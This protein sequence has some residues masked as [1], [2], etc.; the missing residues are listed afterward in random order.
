MEIDPEFQKT[1]VSAIKQLLKEGKVTFETIHL[2]KNGKKIPVEVSAS[3]FD[4][5]GK[6]TVLSI[7]RDITER[8]QVDKALKASEENFRRSL[9]ESPLGVRIVTDAGETIYANR[10]ILDIYGYDS[11]EQLKAIPVKKRYTPESFIEFQIRKEKRQLAEETPSEY[12][13]DIIRKDG[14]VRH[15]QVYRKE[16]IWNGKKQNQVIYQ[17][18]ALRK[19]LEET[20]QKFDKLFHSNPAAMAVTSMPERRFTDVNNAFVKVVGYSRKE[21]IGKTSK[22]LDIFI[23]PEKQQEIADKLQARGTIT[24]L[25]LKI[26]TKDGKI[27]DGLFSGE[28]IESHGKKYFLSVMIDQTERK[29][30]Q[31]KFRLIT[32]NMVDC[33]ALVDASG[34]YQYAT[35]SYRE[36]L[37]YDPE[38]MVGFNGFNLIHPDDQER[39]F[40]LYMECFEKGLRETSY[41]TTLLHKDGHYVPIEIKARAL[42]DPTGKIVGGVLNARDISKRLQLEQERLEVE[43]QKKVALNTLILTEERYRT[44]VENASDIIFRT[45]NNGHFT[46]VNPAALSITGYKKE[47]VIGMDYPALIRQDMRD[48][49]IKFFGRQFV[50][51]IKNTYS[52]FPVIAKDGRELWFGQ[53]TQ[54]IVEGG[55]VTG[56]QSVARDITER[57]RIEQALNDAEE[58]YRNIFLNSQTGLFRTDI[59]TGLMLEANDSM[60]HFA[61][62]KNRAE[63][64]SDNFNI[65]ERYVDPEARQKMLA[66]IKEHGQVAN[67]ETQFRRN[68]GSIIWIRLSANIVPAKGCLE[69][70]AEDITKEKDAREAL[71]KSEERYRSLVENANEAIIVIQDGK[72]K[73]VNSRAI[74]SFGY[75]GE[76]LLAS[77]I[78]DLIHPEDRDVVMQRYLQ[79]I[80]GDTTSSRH[81]YRTIH[82]SGQTPWI[83]ISSVLIDWERRPATLNLI[84]DMS[85]RMQAEED[86]RLLEERLQQAD[87][88]EAIGTLAGGIAHDFNN[89]LMGMQGYA[90]M[91]LMNLNQNDPNYERLKRIEEQ[92]RSGADLT[93]QLLGFARGGRYEVKATS[94]NEIIEKSSTMFGRTKKEITIHH[95]SCSDLWS[96]E[97]DRGQMEQVFLNLFVNAWQAMPGGGDIYLETQNALL[98]GEQA[99][100]YSVMPGK[101]VKITISDTGT[102]MDEKTRE[103]IF[104]PFFTTKEM[105]RGTGLGMATVYGIIKGHE[106]IIN[107][108][109]K[110]GKGTTFTIYLPASEKEVHKEE[111]PTDKIVMGTETILLIDDEKTVMEVNKELLESIGYTLYGAVSGQQG[112]DI[113]MEKK[114]SIDLII[115]DMIMPGIS[116]SDTFDRLREINPNVKILLSSGYSLTGKAQAIM[117]RGCN[118]FLQKPFNLEELSSKVREMLG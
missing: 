12:E 4:M 44:L 6:K 68:D 33:V 99:L 117:D 54:L 97:V 9:D 76:E 69:G 78:F 103:R 67:Y 5:Q 21:V 35:P 73:F 116:G 100:F 64:L 31:E 59:K 51:G 7:V 25:E 56:F 114:D 38:E 74:A 57:K 40:K 87:K 70:V 16:I 52:E 60:A 58:T 55:N 88:M 24:N 2:T 82:K 83:E 13:I 90:S 27:I 20:L 107:V 49:A 72:I 47:E 66:I 23:Q 111:I 89:L 62:Y 11:I 101:H 108:E 28:I 18:I 113:Y 45:D 8:N 36:I 75:S 110:L 96:V 43:A 79:K 30:T 61:G 112:L 1:G 22:E 105:G 50:K 41:E 37:G 48:E 86:K 81:V 71:Q 3:L 94:M 77:N 29:K 118:G 102:G 91:T 26:K 65:A 10:A 53:N 39:I 80:N 93:S 85:E 63:L 95:K 42:N 15:L 14:K 106:G 98:N 104:E 92:V 32:E 84:T 17:D 19:Q 109:S 115:L 46:F 34:N